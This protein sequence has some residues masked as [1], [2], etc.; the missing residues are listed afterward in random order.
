MRDARRQRAADDGRH[1]QPEGGTPRAAKNITGTVVSSS[2][3]MTRGLVSPTYAATTSRDESPAR[4]R[5][6]GGRLGVD[7]GHA[8][9]VSSSRPM[10]V[11]EQLTG[12]YRALRR[13]R[14]APRRE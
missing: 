5:A 13:S 7:R 8:R 9:L 11:D 2:S 12:V 4:D 10:V 1:H 14:R 6:G 3:S